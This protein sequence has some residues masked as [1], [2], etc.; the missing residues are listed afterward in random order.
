MFQLLAFC[1]AFVAPV[2][3]LAGGGRAGPRA[4]LRCHASADELPEPDLSAW[5]TIRHRLSRSWEGDA[6]VGDEG[7]AHTVPSPE[8]GCVLLAKP[9]VRFVRR[10]VNRR[11]V[12]AIQATRH[13][14]RGVELVAD[15]YL[16]G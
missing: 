7:W 16:T 9:N 13:L 5:R 8:P 15:D 10:K 4:A 1:Q 14:P 3:Q 12:L 11:W 2:P 6:T